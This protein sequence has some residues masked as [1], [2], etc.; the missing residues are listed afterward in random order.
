MINIFLVRHGETVW[1]AE[2]RYAGRSEVELSAVGRQQAEALARWAKT[3]EIRKLYVSPQLRA[4]ETMRPVAEAVSIE[5][6][7]DP[8][9]CEVDF[10]LGEGL[11]ARE[12]EQK[13]PEERRRFEADPVL[14]FL[15]GGEDPRAAIARGRSALNVIVE[16][17]SHAGT[18]SPEVLVV[19]HS[20]LIRLLL[21]DALGL[22]PSLYRKVFPQLGCAM[23]TELGFSRDAAPASRVVSLL[24]FNVPPA[25]SD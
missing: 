11:T 17:A 25:I 4:M 18:R 14:H 1:H 19:T 24:R 5:P 20:T 7:I 10:G 8:R 13:M 3:A 21:C 9:L 15:P 6:V 12:M 2:N 16:N 23:L 22:N